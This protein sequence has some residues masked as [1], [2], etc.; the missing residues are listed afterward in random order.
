M[1]DSRQ[2]LCRGTG[3]VVIDTHSPGVAAGTAAALQFGIYESAERRCVVKRIP[4]GIPVIDLGAGIGFISS[5]LASQMPYGSLLSV[6]PNPSLHSV[7]ERNVARNAA[8][9]LHWELL[10]VAV[11]VSSGRQGM[12]I[13]PGGHLGSKLTEPYA[14]GEGGDDDVPTMSLDEISEG[15]DR[16]GLVS[17]VEGSE[18]SF[19]TGGSKALQRCSWLCIELHSTH[20]DG[21]WWS[22]ADLCSEILEKGMSLVHRD[23]SVFVFERHSSLAT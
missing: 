15:F 8:P 14:P 17:D 10:R 13:S 22:Q 2:V 6:E 20:A 7:L 12:S 5:I 19:V 4:H 1:R 23:G 9:G 18:V 16:F 11:Y 3:G 21:R